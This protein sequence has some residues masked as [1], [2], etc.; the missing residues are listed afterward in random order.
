MGPNRARRMCRTQKAI[1]WQ[2]WPGR[3]FRMAHS[4]AV[5][6]AMADRIKQIKPVTFLFL[7]LLTLMQAGTAHGER[8]LAL[9]IGIGDYINLPNLEKAAADAALMAATLSELGFQVTRL[10]NPG[11]RDLN[12]GIGQFAS[13]IS[14]GDIVLVHFSGHGVE[15]DG[16]NFLLPQ[17]AP[18]PDAGGKDAVKY[19]TIALRRLVSQISGAGARA[20]VFVI[21][22][23]RRNPFPKTLSGQVGSPGGLTRLEPPANTFLM[24]SAGY[25]QEALEQLA[26]DDGMPTSVY[27]RVLVRQLKAAGKPIAQIARDVRAEVRELAQSV[28]HDQRPAYYDELS[29]S[30]VLTPA[31]KGQAATPNPQTQPATPIANLASGLSRGQAL[32]LELAYWGEV[33]RS[34]VPEELQSYIDQYPNGRFVTLA[35]L[36][37]ANLGQLLQKQPKTSDFV[38]DVRQDELENR[39]DPD[40][41][42]PADLSSRELAWQMQE[43]LDRL[44]CGPGTPDGVWGAGSRRALRDYLRRRKMRT[45]DLRPSVVRLKEMR[46]LNERVC[47]GN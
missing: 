31:A 20:S 43:E 28:G 25:G 6:R 26:S 16:E 23:N 27:I 17:D 41:D 22:A 34:T 33:R 4:V 11:R 5:S 42:E 29:S 3:H 8:R 2:I 38:Q 12:I 45:I 37:L 14:K 15:I 18:K 30:L 46:R 40:Q 35:K 24:Y 1:V 10:S 7:A 13:G 32:T 19:E 39:D 9:V 36:R 21:D 47:A 44:G